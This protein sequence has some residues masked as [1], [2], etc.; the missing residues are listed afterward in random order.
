M[1]TASPNRPVGQGM[2]R[3]FQTTILALA[4]CA[5]TAVAQNT[6]ITIEGTI[7][8][9]GSVSGLDV[10]GSILDPSSGDWHPVDLASLMR[11]Q[12]SF[13]DYV[14]RKRDNEVGGGTQLVGAG[15]L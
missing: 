11:R 8:S 2:A 10:D 1:K 13:P 14:D 9:I 15:G 6:Q 7:T 12:I 3:S 4:L 5:A